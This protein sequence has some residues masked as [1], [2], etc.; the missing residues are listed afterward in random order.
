MIKAAIR[1]ADCGAELHLWET[2]YSWEGIG[3]LCEDCFEGKRNELSNAEFA[4]LIGS[5]VCTAED[6]IC[7]C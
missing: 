1:C 2:A 7:E 6:L 3:W 4:R 5:E